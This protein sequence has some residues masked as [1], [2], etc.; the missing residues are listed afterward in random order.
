MKAT[1]RISSREARYL[2]LIS[3]ISVLAFLFFFLFTMPNH[4]LI[5]TIFSF[6]GLAIN[7]YTYWTISKIY[8]GYVVEL[9]K[10]QKDTKEYM[11]W[12]TVMF[13]ILFIYLLS[14][15]LEII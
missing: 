3:S 9:T 14:S 10:E 6:I 5:Q 11:G 2:S 13:A 12:H 4:Y 15:Y 1:I 8:K 7:I